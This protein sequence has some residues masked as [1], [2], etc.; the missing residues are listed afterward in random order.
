MTKIKLPP[1]PEPDFAFD[2]GDEPCYYAHTLR[3]RDLEV[4][5]TVQEACAAECD[6]MAKAAYRRYRAEGSPYDDGGCDMANTLATVLR[7]TLEFD[8]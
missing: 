8:V 3:A 7:T 5:R 1:L 2:Q 4:A 6:M